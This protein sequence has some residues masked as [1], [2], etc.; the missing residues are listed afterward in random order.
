M[1]GI[2]RFA[3]HAVEINSLYPQV[4]TLCGDYRT[5]ARPERTLTVTP[6]DIAE[7]RRRSEEEG[8]GESHDA[9]LETLAVYRKI[10]E[11]LIE[12][13][14]LLFHGS[15]VAAD[16][17]C[18]LF[19]AKSGTGKSTHAR[20]WRELLG[21]RA[22][23]VNDDKPLLEVAAGGVTVWGTPW[24]GKHHLSRNMAVPLGAVCLLE[25]GEE[26][27]IEPVSAREAWPLLWRQTYRPAEG[28]KLRRTLALTDRLAHSV[29]LYRLR[30]RPEIEA[31]RMA[32]ETMKKGKRP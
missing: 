20:L 10:A 9:Y 17:T 15:A 31:A 19:A 32:Y 7:E 11:S 14:I 22:V 5:E 29:P 6:G 21:E 13:N 24:D 16:G 3:G 2:Y 12:E 25:R 18:Y 26:N 30:C 4:H 28:E 1:K 8:R 27:A 23:M